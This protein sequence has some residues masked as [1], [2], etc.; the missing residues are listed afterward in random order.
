MDFTST[1]FILVLT[2]VGGVVAVLADWLGRKLGKRK[3]RLGKLRP[4]HTAILLTGVSGALVTIITIVLVAVFSAEVRQL[5]IEGREAVKNAQKDKK[6]IEL[7]RSELSDLSITKNE[8]QS[9][10]RGTQQTLS[11]ATKDIEYR[12]TELARLQIEFDRDKAAFGRQSASY[13]GKLKGLE[14]LMTKR[15]EA[16]AKLTAS[17]KKADSLYKQLDAVYKG[18]ESNYRGLQA[19]YKS[20]DAQRG[21]LDE[22]NA[23]LD[24]QNQK[25]TDSNA[26]L[27][28][29]SER[30]TKE[31][32]ALREDIAQ[33]QTE[34]QVLNIK[35][36]NASTSAVSARTAPIAFERGEEFERREVSD[37]LTLDDALAVIR[38]ALAKANFVV[39]Q[40]SNLRPFLYQAVD[41]KTGNEIGGAERQ[42]LLARRLLAVRGQAVVVVSSLLNSFVNDP[43]VAL[44]INIYPNPVVFQQG[45]VL[46]EARVDG[47][48]AESRIV[49][50]IT[51]LLQTTVRQKAMDAK[52]IPNGVRN[53]TFGRIDPD[54]TIRIV[55][56]IKEFGRAVRLQ[57]LAKE[58][59]RAAGPLNIEF[60]VR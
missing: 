46:G 54:E 4:R 52:M 7:L 48:L 12:K 20:L 45:Q 25:L 32:N 27:N 39:N 22:Q 8:S 58:S 47:G 38:A 34:L 13:Q 26:K 11:A 40:R 42:V 33:Q 37:I 2:F 5:L 49:Q 23:K 59:T 1:W 44:D 17:L 36:E 3:L 14:G 43:S 41:P 28:S 55:T 31:S 56:Q 15:E 30:L 29:E 57:A 21:E 16:L 24:E 60:R 35:F 18:L 51:D 53:S 6:A 50:Q 9:Q 19:N 10:L